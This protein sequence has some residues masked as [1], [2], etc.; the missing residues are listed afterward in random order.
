MAGVQAA[1]PGQ[2]HTYGAL[3]AHQQQTWRVVAAGLAMPSLRMGMIWLRMRSPIL[4]TCTPTNNRET[5]EGSRTSNVRWTTYEPCFANRAF[6]IG[7]PQQRPAL[8]LPQLAGSHFS[9]SHKHAAHQL[10]QAAA[11]H[12]A[13]VLACRG[14]AQQR[15]VS[16]V[17]VCV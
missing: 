14:A 2:A 8:A 15:Q 1:G 16:V 4:R 3:H 9:T 5:R 11:R 13:P 7:W 6:F 12:L 10:S 17:R